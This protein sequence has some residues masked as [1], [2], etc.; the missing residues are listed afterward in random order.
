MS[1]KLSIVE[2]P[3]YLKLIA[4]GDHSAAEMYSFI[5]RIKAEAVR[6]RR[7]KVLVDSFGYSSLMS[8][9]EKFSLG[10]H[11]AKVFGPQ[12]K[13][14]IMLPAEHISKLGELTAE[15]RGADLLVTSSETEAISW[16]LA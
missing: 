15:N 6:A 2:D 8:E 11:L 9:T 12:L 13:V 3:D 4:T 7:Q 1:Y 10:C 14:A 16:L 5:D